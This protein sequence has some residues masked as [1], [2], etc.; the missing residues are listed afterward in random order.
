MYSWEIKE[1]EEVCVDSTNWLRL[2]QVLHKVSPQLSDS[3]YMNIKL[4]NI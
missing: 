1:T 2:T 3:L 4:K